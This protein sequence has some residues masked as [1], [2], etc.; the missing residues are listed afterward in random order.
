MLTLP[1][2]AKQRYYI[3]ALAG[4]GQCEIKTPLTSKTIDGSPLI[5]IKINPPFTKCFFIEIDKEKVKTLS[6]LLRDF[7]QDRCEIREGDCNLIIDEILSQIPLQAPCFAFLDPEG[8]EVDWLTYE[9]IANHKKDSKT[10]IELFILFPYNMAF[11]R[12]LYYNRKR[13]ERENIPLLLNKKLPKSRWLDVYEDRIKGKLGQLEV[14]MRI[15]RI[16]IDGLKTLGYNFVD[17]RL[18]KS[19]LGRPLYYMVFATDHPAGAKIMDYVF[20]KDWI[21]GQISFIDNLKE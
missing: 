20:E 15:L 13:F 3:D 4:D 18:I 1:K 5:A 10:K 17:S 21:G 9:K 12:V 2:K 16:F 19:N 6:K 7:P 8:F 11:A 14:R